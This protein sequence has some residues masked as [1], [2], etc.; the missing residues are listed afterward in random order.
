MSEEANEQ[1]KAEANRISLTHEQLNERLER[2]RGQAL[3]GQL[4]EL[5]F[6]N[7][8]ALRERLEALAKLEKA[9]QE[10]AAA[11]QTAL[12][13]SQ[14]TIAEKEARIAELQAEQAAAVEAREAM[15]FE[16]SVTKACASLGIQNVDYA[17]YD[18]I[19]ATEALG[20]ND[21]ALDVIEH[22]KARAAD[23]ARAAAFGARVETVQEP[24]TTVPEGA[25]TKPDAPPE[26]KKGGVVDA[27]SLG[28]KEW[29]AQKAA[30]G[31]I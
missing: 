13:R 20:D 30:L 9:E 4:K 12:E 6:D 28:D 25:T 7:A 3:G 8:D 1:T 18:V 21:P 15:A 24:A 14:A 31:I 17:M 5:G 19:Q 26:A 10:R 16:A 2:A 23:P 27:H 11:E 29:A 22:L